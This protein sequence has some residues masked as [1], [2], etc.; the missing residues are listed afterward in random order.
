MIEAVI[1]DMDGVLIDSEPMWK[2]AEKKVFSSLGVDITE[3][4]SAKTA[5]MTTQ[6]VTQFWYELYP[7][8]GKTLAQVENEV[9][10][11]VAHLILE[12]GTS[13][14]GVK[15]ALH[16]FKDKKVK[17]G[18]STNAPSRLIPIVL[19]TL[20]IADYF[21]AISS[22]EFEEKGKPDP[23]VYLSTA[24]KLNV[25]PLTCV[26]FEDSFSGICAARNAN[27]RVV[28]VPSSKEFMDNKFALAH[29]KIRS[30]E[31]F[32]DVHFSTLMLQQQ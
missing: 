19:N 9:V 17:V 11:Y 30:L 1:F 21:Q 29:M 22:S 3:A 24:Q 6:E 18:L 16:F 26:V 27:M 14:K 8:Q 7:W 4:L 25:D 12:K 23:A 32:S 31:E 13:I 20:G 10:D 5:S 28:A 2:E 15:E